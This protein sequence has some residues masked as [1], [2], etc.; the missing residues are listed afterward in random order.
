MSPSHACTTAPSLPNSTARISATSATFDRLLSDPTPALPASSPTATPSTAASLVPLSSLSSGTA[1]TPASGSARELHPIEQGLQALVAQPRSHHRL[2]T[3]GVG[4]CSLP[5][6]RAGRQSSFILKEMNC[7]GGSFRAQ[8]LHH[9]STSA[10]TTLLHTVYRAV[11][12]TRVTCCHTKSRDLIVRRAPQP[13]VWCRTGG[14]LCA[15]GLGTMTLAP[16]RG[17]GAAGNQWSVVTH[18]NAFFFVVSLTKVRFDLDLRP[19]L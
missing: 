15:P 8:P 5:S 4:D 16:A 6:G 14:G 17:R 1:S 7:K 18:F 19:Q 12:P 13:L 3:A 11:L 2:E 10:T 9:S